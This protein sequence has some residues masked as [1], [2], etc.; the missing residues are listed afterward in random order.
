MNM[1]IDERRRRLLERYPT[2]EPRTL[3]GHFSDVARAYPDRPVVLTDAREY[4]YSAMDA[5][6]QDMARGLIAH[7][8]QPGEHVALVMA[9]HPEFIALRMAIAA[10]GA[11]SVPVNYL[12]RDNELRYALAQSD[13][14]ALVTMES[15]A[16]L[17]YLATLDRLAPGWEHGPVAAFPRLRSVIT[18]DPAGGS[19]PGVPTL[20][21]LAAVG[22]TVPEEALAERART[23]GADDLAEI[24]Y[25]SG[26]TGSA[27]GV[28]LTH[29]NVLRCAY[30][31]AVTRGLDDGH[32]MLFALPLY[33]NFGSIEGFLATTFV[34]GAVAPHLTFEVEHTFA[35]IERFGIQ[36]GIFVP[37]MT[38][39]LVN[40]P[41]RKEYDLRSLH[42][43]MSG[44]APAP[45]RLWEQ[46][47]SELG[48]DEIVTAYGQTEVAAS[49]TYT[50]PGDPLELISTTVGRPK[51]GWVAAPAGAD[52]LICEYRTIDPITQEFLPAGSDGELVVRGP[53]VMRG[54]Y[55][56]PD[57]TA[58]VFVDGWLRSGDLGYVGDDGYLRLTGR[59]KELYK[60]GGELVAP[61]EVE[62][63]LSTM[64]GVSQAFVVGVPDERWGEAGCAWIVPED[65]EDRS[66]DESH[67]VAAC[68]AELA[69]FKV[70]KH[71]LFISADDLPTTPTGKVQ[72]FKLVERA[73]A[74]LLEP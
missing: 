58:A 53:Q 20:Q 31:S 16:G 43:V 47:R 32:R 24:V 33:H 17:D 5:W 69:R 7:G 55:D 30:S 39:A 4:T 73:R 67:V 6:A 62:E 42:T 59:S 2:W 23:A 13:A 40:H 9:N 52:G 22:R 12:M 72:K 74:W 25:T 54:Y 44:G 34:A 28:M 8:V 68:K 71:V 51:Q 26:T 56:K 63:F 19:R 36:S 57:E 46:V 66:I 37:T 18:F 21:G 3:S 29:D 1:S 41:A 70:P 45:V 48:V 35:S 10:I 15:F 14:V 65:P 49:S 11:V 50:L 64:P 60:T 38:V 61:K 27:K